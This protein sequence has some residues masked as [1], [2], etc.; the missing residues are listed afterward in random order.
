MKKTLKFITEYSLPLIIGV[1]LA[2][3][4]ANIN[5]EGYS[6]FETAFASLI[7]HKVSFKFLVNDIF[8]A[9]FFG[10]AMAEIVH[11]VKSQ[12]GADYKETVNT[13]F[14]TLGG[15]VIP[16]L[17]F[18]VFFNVFSFS[19]LLG[20][21]S[22]GEITKENIFRGWGIP[23]ATDIALAWL[24]AKIVFGASHPAINYLVLLAIID[25][26]IGM[27]IIAIFYPNPAHPFHPEYLA[28]IA[29]AMLIAFILRKGKVQNFWIYIIICGTISWFG[30]LLAGLHAALSLIFIVPFLPTE[31]KNNSSSLKDFEHF[32]NYPIAFGLFFF[33]LANA[34]V[35]VTAPNDLTIAIFLSLLIG[36]VLGIFGLGLL[37]HLLGFK[38]ARSIGLKGLFLI[39]MISGVGLTVALFVSEQA[40]TNLILKESAKMGS[41]LSILAGFIA[42]ALKFFIKIKKI[43]T[44][45]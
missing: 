37:A 14:A 23:T 12:S 7:G 41:L 32:F 25:D 34:G 11:S 9:F 2:L 1:V 39:G 45:D 44:K 31:E 5:K 38:I 10:V 26:A 20:L 19:S 18:I 27:L 17:T 16:I 8:M 30:M 13:L 15:I 3:F 35:A 21:E 22:G 24:F 28:L 43:D 40:Y 36:K 33:G 6:I 42:I 4:W 29:V